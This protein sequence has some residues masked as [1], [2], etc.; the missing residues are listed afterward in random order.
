MGQAML[1]AAAA[2]DQVMQGA[3]CTFLVIYRSG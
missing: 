3:G 1:M 2:F